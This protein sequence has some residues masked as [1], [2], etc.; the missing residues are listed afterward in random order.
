MVWINSILRWCRSLR[1]ITLLNTMVTSMLPSRK[2]SP[3]RTGRPSQAPRVSRGGSAPS[4]AGV[5]APTLSNLPD[6]PL[7][8]LGK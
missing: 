4:T 5:N 8:D 2:R 3:F 1:T 7:L 6:P